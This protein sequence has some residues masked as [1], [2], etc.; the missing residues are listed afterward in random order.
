[1][2]T[3][4][5]ILERVRTILDAARS[6]AKPV[7]QSYIEEV[8]IVTEGYAEP[9]YNDP[10]SEVIAFGNWNDI[11]RYDEEQGKLIVLDK[12]MPRVCKL[13]E[14]LGVEIEWS[15]E[16]TTC[17]ECGKAVRTQPDSYGWQRSYWTTND[18]DDVCV[19]CVYK[20]PG[21]YVESMVGEDHR[22]ITIRGIDLEQF[23][24]VELSER[25]EY[26]L[27]GGQSD[28]PGVIGRSLRKKGIDRYVF[29]IDDVGQFD[30]KFKVWVDKTQLAESNIK[31]GVVES[32]GVDPAVTMK[33]YLRSAAIAKVEPGPKGSRK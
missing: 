11:T 14:R 8:W 3:K 4:R 6:V 30:L 22:A 16:W 24:F 28:D 29:V 25:Y 1:M 33:N 27:Y 13:L 9:G 20:S 7:A 21:D 12:T 31:G 26:G 2:R 17:Y 32:K 15:D 5:M 18:G 19:E 23:G 10:S